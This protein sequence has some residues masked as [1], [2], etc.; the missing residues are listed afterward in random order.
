MSSIRKI[1]A[2]KTQKNGR[3]KEEENKKIEKVLKIHKKLTV[4]SLLKKYS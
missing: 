2:G 1:G 3:S 4:L